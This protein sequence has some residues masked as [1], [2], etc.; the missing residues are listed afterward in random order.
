MFV[1][2]EDASKEDVIE[3]GSLVIIKRTPTPCTPT[4]APIKRGSSAT[5]RGKI[6]KHT[7]P[8]STPIRAPIIR[9]TPTPS[10]PTRAPIIRSP[11]STTEAP[12]YQSS[13]SKAKVESMDDDTI[14]TCFQHVVLHDETT[15]CC[16]HCKK[17]KEIDPYWVESI[18]TY[19]KK[20]GIRSGFFPKTCDQQQR[21]NRQTNQTS[22]WYYPKIHK[23]DTVEYYRNLVINRAIET[24]ENGF[25]PCP[26]KFKI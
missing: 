25:I 17:P 26:V 21:I 16:T 2:G 13:Y 24:V 5:N 19:C 20:H 6:I 11:T 1:T 4:R 23:A 15:L 8:P 18:L 12:L 10:T 9:P 22:N 14:I 7:P 3:P